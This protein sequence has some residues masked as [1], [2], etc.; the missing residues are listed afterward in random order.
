MMRAMSMN[1][2]ASRLPRGPAWRWALFAALL[3]AAPSAFAYLDP[4]TGS[5]ILSAIVGIFATLGLAI[6]TYW[7]KLKNLVLR[8]SR[9]A[10]AGAARPVG[11]QASGAGPAASTAATE[12]ATHAPAP[13][14]QGSG[15]EPG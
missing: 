9:P 11:Q 14:Q 10:D 8:G 13:G 6:K 4:S 5:M 3:G 7:Y 15:S 2:A 1:H 12:T